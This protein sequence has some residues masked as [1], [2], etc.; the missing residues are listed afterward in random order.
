MQAT[1]KTR[2][3]FTYKH[4]ID[5][6]HE[7][8]GDQGIFSSEGMTNRQIW[9]GI[10]ERL[11]LPQETER[12]RLVEELLLLEREAEEEEKR[13]A[14]EK[15]KLEHDK[16]TSGKMIRESALKTIEGGAKRQSGKSQLDQ[17]LTALTDSSRE[18]KEK[19]FALQEGT[20]AAKRR[21]IES[22]KEVQLR[23][24]QIQETNAAAAF[25]TMELMKEM[26]KQLRK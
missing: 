5:I 25:Q 15:E 3:R 17:F 20:L 9:M 13:V 12:I 4:D 22:D 14:E 18:Q 19:E 2:F 16:E 8:L 23:A 7:D 21:K 10:H 6:L 26:M 11:G 24:L 1:R